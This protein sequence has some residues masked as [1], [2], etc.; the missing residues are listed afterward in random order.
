MQAY[1]IAVCLNLRSSGESCTIFD[2][3]LCL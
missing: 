1:K 2:W 3:F